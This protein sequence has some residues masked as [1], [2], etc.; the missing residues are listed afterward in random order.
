[1]GK[2]ENHLVSKVVD[3]GVELGHDALEL[4]KE[5]FLRARGIEPTPNSHTRLRGT[6]DTGNPFANRNGPVPSEESP[7]AAGPTS[8]AKAKPEPQVESNI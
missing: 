3:D 6:E 2:I 7:K 8:E 1:M 5:M 4:F